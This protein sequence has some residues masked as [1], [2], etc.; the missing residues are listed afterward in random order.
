MRGISKERLAL[1]L[2]DIPSGSFLTGN[3]QGNFKIMFKGEFYGVID[4]ND[5][6]F[7][8]AEVKEDKK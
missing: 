8:P 3:N 4:V 1:L 7:H 2:S 5:K 6:T